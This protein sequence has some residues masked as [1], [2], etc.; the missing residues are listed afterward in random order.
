M[1]D[2][3]GLLK[4]MMSLIEDGKWDQTP[5]KI[6]VI[7]MDNVPNNGD[8][9][10]KY[11]VEIA[12]ASSDDGGDDDTVKMK[13]FL[14]TRVVFL[15][16]MVD[17]ITSQRPGS[18]G[19]VP[20]CEPT[21]AKALVI[22]DPQE[23]LPKS[24][25]FSNQPGVVIRS[26]Q[27][28]LSIDINLK[29]RVANGTHTAIAHT[30]ALL[31]HN[32]TDILAPNDATPSSI[33]FMKY[34]DA[35]VSDQIIPAACKITT[36][37]E[38]VA[39]WKDWRQRLIH[40][41]FGLS[42]FFITQNG[43]AK[44]GIRFGPTVV[45]LLS[46]ADGDNSQMTTV[47][48]VFAYASLLRWLTPIPCE[49]SYSSTSDNVFVGWL[50]GFSAEDIVKAR[51]LDTENA[52]VYAD[53]LRHNHEQGWYEFKCSLCVPSDDG[54]VDST[55]PLTRLLK[56]CIGQQPD[57][58]INAVKAY[59]MASQGGDLSSVRSAHGLQALI[60]AVAVIYSRMVSGDSL[61]TI[62]EELDKKSFSTPSSDIS[63][64]LSS[65]QC[66]SGKRRKIII[67]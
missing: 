31:R 42:S 32:Q 23:D 33:L 17:R 62:L 57:G 8:L 19:L 29:L 41:H 59:M 20:R 38:A 9:I 64:G 34:L 11:M 55:I 45:D 63:D 46:N 13:K 54:Q 40:P 30:L 60:N 44:G 21:P 4:L 49:T 39:V 25:S 52:V 58:C 22:L 51:S 48:L 66:D 24:D 50:D 14:T 61:L 67:E 18:D 10:A 26:T 16:T 53:G 27:E 2:L 5:R 3:Y 1:K 12:T 36:K 6:C 47:S 28:Q 15:N 7:D 37:H 35:L 56:S 65:Q 43:P